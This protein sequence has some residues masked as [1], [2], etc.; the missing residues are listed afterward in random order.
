MQF[1]QEDGTMVGVKVRSVKSTGDN[2]LI[3]AMSQAN[4]SLGRGF[5]AQKVRD[6]LAIPAGAI[7]TKWCDAIASKL[8]VT[9]ALFRVQDNKLLVV[10]ESEIVGDKHVNLLLIDGHYWVIVSDVRGLRAKTFQ[11][12]M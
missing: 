5:R 11:G 10:C 1:E 6:E 12:S 9:Y 7:E 4:A 3:N 2:C 8:E